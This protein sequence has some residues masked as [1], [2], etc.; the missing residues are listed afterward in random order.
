MAPTSTA[1][2]LSPDDTLQFVT[3]HRPGLLSGDYAIRLQQNVFVGTDAVR[4]FTQQRLFSVLGERFSL[5]PQDVNA[6]FPPANGRGNF[7]RD[8][9]HIILSCS[10]LPWERSC[11]DGDV[12]PGHDLPWLALLLFHEDE[13]ANIPTQHVALSTLTSAS[14]S[15]W[16]PAVKLESGQ[17]ANDQAQVI[18]VPW[19]TLNNLLPHDCKDT[20]SSLYYLNQNL[21]YLNH[22]RIV[23]GDHQRG[24][25]GNSYA[26]R[27]RC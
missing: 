15:P 6:V 16:W 8:L 23:S 25:F 13:A 24:A 10:T 21:C 4:T 2:Q 14:P 27:D 11:I 3:S 22:A 9:P 18:D 17:V 5:T 20:S 7:W 19:S 1:P 12:D 26:S